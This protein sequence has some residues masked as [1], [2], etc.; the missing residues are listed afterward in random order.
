MEINKIY[1]NGWKVIR[2]NIL[3]NLKKH[4]FSDS[5]SIKFFEKKYNLY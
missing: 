3:P 1:N 5:D 2:E 4:F